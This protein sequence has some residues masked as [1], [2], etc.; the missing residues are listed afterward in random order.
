[1]GV[2]QQVNVPYRSFDL[3]VAKITYLC[4]SLIS[5]KNKNI[6]E[7]QAIEKFN[8]ILAATNG[9]L[10]FIQMST[11]RP[12]GFEL[13]CDENNFQEV[14]RN[15]FAENQ[16]IDLESLAS[17]ARTEDEGTENEDN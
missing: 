15:N 11:L 10:G 13:N 5:A 4:K 14:D 12:E 6:E 8:V 1:L 9:A 7:I 3:P 2:I 16:A 17:E